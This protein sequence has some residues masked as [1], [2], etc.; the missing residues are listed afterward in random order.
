[1][2]EAEARG[3]ED[4]LQRAVASLEAE[5]VLAQKVGGRRRK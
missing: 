4:L 5:R 3:F 1:M 2:A